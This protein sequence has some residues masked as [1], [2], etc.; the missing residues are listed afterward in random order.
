MGT[1]WQGAARFSFFMNYDCAVGLRLWNSH[2]L[3]TGA[4]AKGAAKYII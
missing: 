3:K 2:L 4:A 1:K